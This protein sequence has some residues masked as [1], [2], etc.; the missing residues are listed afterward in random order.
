MQALPVIKDFYVIKDSAAR[1]ILVL[2][3]PPVGQFVLQVS[4]EA[5][6]HGVVPAIPRPAHAGDHGVLF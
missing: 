3:V 2:E 4:E 6:R 1:L 5:L